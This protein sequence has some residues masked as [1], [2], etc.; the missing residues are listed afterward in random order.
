MNRYIITLL[1]LSLFILSPIYSQEKGE[2]GVVV[3]NKDV[4]ISAQVN[5]KNTV[6]KINYSFDLNG[7]ELRV[8][9][10]CVFLFDGGKI[11]NGTIVFSDTDLQG[12]PQIIGCKLRGTVPK[13]EITWFGAQR[14]NR[15]VDVGTIIN[16]IQDVARHI[17]IP[18][19]EFYQTKEAIRVEG[20]KYIEWIGS[21]ISVCDKTEF[22]SFTISSGVMTLD[23]KGSLICKST[24]IE[25]S[26]PDQTSINGLV[27]ENIYN[28]SIHIGTVHGFNVGV[29]V[30]GFG[31]GCSYNTFNIQAIRECNTGILITQRDRNGKRGWANENTFIG[32]RFGVSSSWDIKSRETHAVV[33]KSIYSDDSYNK[34]NSLYFLRPCAEGSFVPFVFNN[35]EIISVVECRT[36]RGEVGAILSGKTNRV[37]L[38]NSSGSSLN[39]VDVSGL[40][41]NQSRPLFIR[42]P[43]MD[44]LT[45]VS[46]DKNDLNYGIANDKG[47]V[48]S[49]NFR[50]ITYRGEIRK[51]ASPISSG[52]VS[53]IGT[54][55]VFDKSHN[56][57]GRTINIDIPKN[58]GDSRR[59]VYLLVKETFDGRTVSEDDISFAQSM[60]YNKT[61]GY[62]VTGDDLNSTQI[63]VGKNVKQIAVVFRNIT[64]VSIN[65]PSGARIVN[66]S[67]D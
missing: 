10:G 21:I 20:S 57:A 31:A 17:V 50:H 23:M 32:G 12:Y 42:Q 37:F 28:S 1:F 25:Y 34:V 63:I 46:F 59:Y 45:N 53:E 7:D 29:K 33:A 14:G 51:T 39:N 48:P 64:R 67:L 60:S 4:S 49:G 38:S 16:Q 58:Q 26:E 24:A 41:K 65:L 30:F 22:D 55:I 47:F 18:A 44:S 6:Y 13:A 8:P 62:W 9:E 3:L 54:E 43:D 36:E 66:S 52:D 35:A 27:L 40:T 5:K 19:G 61:N 11:S 2:D 15:N 56:V